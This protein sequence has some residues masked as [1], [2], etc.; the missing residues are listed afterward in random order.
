MI[1]SGTGNVFDLSNMNFT[2]DVMM[3]SDT[4]FKAYCYNVV[5][6]GEVC[7]KHCLFPSNKFFES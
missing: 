2:H 1:F 5:L 7:V 6:P 3:Y 4:V